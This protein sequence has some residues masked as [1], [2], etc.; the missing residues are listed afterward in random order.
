MSQKI[1]LYLSKTNYN[2]ILFRKFNIK[3]EA[4]VRRLIYKQEPMKSS[5]SNSTIS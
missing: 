1:K 5:L 2:N 3:I 4:L